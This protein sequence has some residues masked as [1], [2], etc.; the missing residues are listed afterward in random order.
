M[1]AVIT[2]ETRAEIEALIAEHAWLVDHG[3]ADRIHELYT[4]DGCLL[5]IGP[6]MIGR[7]AIA[8][9]GKGRGQMTDRTARH[10]CANIRLVAESADRIRGTVVNMLFRHDGPGR[11][12][13]ETM[14]VADYEDIYARDSD[15][16]W[17]IAERRLVIVFEA[18]AHRK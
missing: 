2:A 17:R 15:G 8:A 5:G 4:A 13:P 3:H 9:Y 12:L 7:E 18:E 10:V 6:D 16:R 1:A 14:A 11:G